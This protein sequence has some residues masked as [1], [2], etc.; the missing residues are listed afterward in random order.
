MYRA[1][2]SIIAETRAL[3]FA[4]RS[5]QNLDFKP[6]LVKTDALQVVYRWKN[7]C[8]DENEVSLILEDVKTEATHLGIVGLAYCPQPMLEI[9]IF[10]NAF[11]LVK[12]MLTFESILDSF[13]FACLVRGCAENFDV[14]GLG[15]THGGLLVFGLGVDSICSSSLLSAY[16]KLGLVNKARKVFDRVVDLD[17]PL[18][19]SMMSGYGL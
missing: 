1:Q 3:R 8:L 5:T 9:M 11:S 16:S 2:S 10:R 4:F 6:L 17:L 15:C 13:A 18:Q 19:N 7:P 12:E 14:C